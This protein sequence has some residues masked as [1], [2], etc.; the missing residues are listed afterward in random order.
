MRQILVAIAWLA[1][2]LAIALGAAG[3]V[4]G[5]EAPVT[6]DSHPW[7]T[8]RD[9]AAVTAQLDSIAA[10]LGQVSDRLD[11]L[12]TQ[13][14]AALAALTANDQSAAT[15]AIDAG[16]A[17]I[18]DILQRSSAISVALA[19][20]P[21]IGTPAGEYRLG[22]AVRERHARL[23]AALAE[24]SGLEATW[25]RL[26]GGSAA[27]TRLS[28]LLAAHDEAVLAAAEQGRDAEY[29]N[30]I[31]VLD[32]ADT[33]IADARRLRD[34]LARN[35]DV[36]TLDQW[37]D[38]SARYD[39]ALRALYTALDKSGGRVTATVRTAMTEER[40]AKDGL[41][42]DT[43]GLVLIMAEIGR[44][45]MNGAVIGIEQAR[46]ELADA[47]VEPTASPAP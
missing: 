6:A 3:I 28:Q 2:V 40:K 15:A 31:G 4:A 38:R 14:R 21:L 33:A 43:R 34:Q 18:I 25:G 30:A 1:A 29:A 7:Q 22:P 26:A 19:D 10:D 45:G 9:D 42:P 41:P 36:T 47:L 16:D 27:A 11:D 12:G 23:T 37:L 39:L 8:A 13:A 32:Q 17:L 5:M 20:V 35:I 46:G 24:T 44:G